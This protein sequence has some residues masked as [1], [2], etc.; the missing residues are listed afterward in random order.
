MMLCRR[1]LAVVISFAT[2][3]L[4]AAPAPAQQGK[5]VGVEEVRATD[6]LG[7]ARYAVVIGINTYQDATIPKLNYAEADARAIHQTLID[8]Q[9]GGIEPKNAVLLLGKDATTRNIRK[10]LTDL[11]TIPKDATVFIFFSGHGAKEAGEAFW[12]T[13]DSEL[14]GLGFSAIPDREVRALTDR[15]PSNRL[16]M[17]LDCCYAAATVK[18]QKSIV[19]IAEALKSFVG[20][21]RVTITASGPGDEAIEA[22]DLA[23]GVFAHY[24]LEALRGK[25]DGLGGPADGIV[26]LPE[27]TAYLDRHVADAARQRKGIQKPNIFMEEV[28]EPGKFLVTIDPKRLLDLAAAAQRES[29]LVRQRIEALKKMFVD[30]RIDDS[31]YRLGKSLLESAPDRLDKPDRE[32]LAIFVELIAGAVP[33]NRLQALLDSVETPEQRAARLERERMAARVTATLGKLEAAFEKKNGDEAFRLLGELTS[34]SP[35]HPALDDW[36]KRV[37]GLGPPKELTLDLGGGV[38]LDLVLIPAGEFMMGS[39]D[40]EED[41]DSDEGPQHRVRIS[42]PFYMGK[43]EVTQAQWQAIMGSNPSRFK[44]D[45]TLPVDSVSW[46][47]CQ[48]FCKKLSS[49]SGKEVRLPSEAEWEYACRAGTTTRFCFGDSDSS[50]GSYAWYDENS[51]NKTHSVG[52]KRANAW[53]L[54][55]MHGNVWEWCEDTHHDNYTGAPTDGR[56]WTTGGKQTSRVLR[57]GSW[58]IGD[59]WVLRSAFRSRNTPDFRN[60]FNGLR[61][62]AGISP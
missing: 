62:A 55:D 51:D 52:G 43:Y 19:D 11:R 39:P 31:Q 20:K 4:S 48:A 8:P 7:A 30:E 5:A 26:T 3:W 61:V 12:V 29:D 59:R 33:A 16:I 9:V 13:T 50:L 53:G 22:D 58:V 56:A 24:L 42:K 1:Q 35:S 25:A 17:L 32:R 27:L 47:D 57:G 41:R 28:Q 34:L 6:T 23:H 10:A 21:G 45:G 37:E 38:K 36:R 46:E 18:E 14:G 54:H 44:G 2:A 49:R 60:F 40:D 15:I